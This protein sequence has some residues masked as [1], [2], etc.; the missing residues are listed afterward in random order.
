[1]NDLCRLHSLNAYFGDNNKLSIEEFYNYCI[2]YDTIVDGLK[3]QIM[4]GFSM[5]RCII[6]YIIEKIDNKFLLLIPINSYNG[7]RNDIDIDYY[8]NI[9]FNLNGFFEFNKNHIW[10]NKNE[11]NQWIKIDN[12]NGTHK[13]NLPKINNNGY[14]LLIDN[15]YIFNELNNYL[16][17]LSNRDIENYEEKNEVILNNLYYCIKCIKLNKNNN[18]E[19]NKKINILKDIQN[20]LENYLL[21]KNKRDLTIIKNLSNIFIYEK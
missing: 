8:N 19:F 2:E 13:I 21:K 17:I 18:L 12:L 11:N 3:T 4:D 16:K 6:S 14:L 9:I 10:Y 7:I 20:S 15:E 5:G 1:M